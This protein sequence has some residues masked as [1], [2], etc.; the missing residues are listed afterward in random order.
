MMIRRGED[1][2]AIDSRPPT[3]RARFSVRSATPSS[4]LYSYTRE[5]HK[6]K[7]CAASSRRTALK[8]DMLDFVRIMR[9]PYLTTS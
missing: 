4:S 3:P 6:M 2:E 5:R 8:V 1:E 9:R 7:R